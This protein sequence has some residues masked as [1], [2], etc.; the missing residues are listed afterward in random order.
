VLGTK[1]VFR[2][3]SIG[4]TLARYRLDELLELLPG[5]R[6]LRWLRGLLPAPRGDI[7]SLSRGARLRLCL[8]ALGPLFVKF[9][10]ILSTRRDLLPADI[11]D[12]LILLQDRVAPFPGIDAEREIERSLGAPIGQLFKVF[13]R[14]PLASASIAQVHMALLPDDTEVVVKVLRPGVEKRIANDL[15]LLKLIAGIAERHLPNADKIQPREIVAEI[16][17]TLKNEVDLQRE[18]ANAS[19]LRRNFEDSPDLLVP[20]VFWDWSSERVLTLERVRGIPSNDREALDIAGIDRAALAEKGVRVFYQQVFRDNFF[21]ADAHPG[22]I[23][24]DTAPAETPRFIALDFGIMGALTEDDQ[25]YL[26]ENFRAMFSKNYRRIAQ[27]HIEAGW[28]PAHVRVDELEAAVRSVCEPYFTKPLAEISLGEV[29]AKIFKL[30]QR[31]EL[32]IQPQLMLLQKTLLNIEGVG[33]LLHPQLD[34]FAVAQPV[35]EDIV[36]KRYSLAALRSS[37]EERLPELMRNAPDMPR[38]LHAWLRQ[39]SRGE[40][41]MEIR[42]K[43]MQALVDESRE[44][45]RRTVFAV[46]GAGLLVAAALLY[47]LDAQGPRWIGLPLA[48]WVALAGSVAAFLAALHRRT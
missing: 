40:T 31:Y 38:L 43:E 21:H 34:L 42:S 30:A 15:G 12:E 10:Q 29:L 37:F 47:A 1:P 26:A 7:G 4:A 39:V 19:Q 33:R 32:T 2:L 23:W 9:G 11:S 27:L 3:I 48:L 16:E 14:E 24:V 35:L 20:R 28:M 46:L 22:N 25:Y 13:N 5:L 44:G 45:Q 6:L 8:Q 17:R 18:G 36:Q 41:S